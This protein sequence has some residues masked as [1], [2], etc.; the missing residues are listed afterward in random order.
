MLIIEK[1]RYDKAVVSSRAHL[2]EVCSH[3]GLGKHVDVVHPQLI[4]VRVGPGGTAEGHQVSI[5]EVSTV[6]G[7]LCIVLGTAHAPCPQPMLTALHWR[8]PLGPPKEGG[9]QHLRENQALSKSGFSK[10]KAGVS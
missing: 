9:L 1:T 3:T 10:P 5:L 7:C 4:S 2:H 6:R 8:G